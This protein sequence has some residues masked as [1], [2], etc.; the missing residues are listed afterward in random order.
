MSNATL[1]SA[2]NTKIL[3]MQSRL[4]QEEDYIRLIEM[5]TVD[6]QIDYLNTQTQYRDRLDGV[7]RV[8]EVELRMNELRYDELSKLQHYFSAGYRAF[9][10]A[11]MRRFEVEQIKIFLRG[12]QNDDPLDPLKLESILLHRTGED[13]PIFR[14]E[15][16]TSI[17]AYIENLRDT[18][19]FEVLSPYADDTGPGRL[20]YME[21]LLDK[22]YFKQLRIAA[23]GLQKKDREIVEQNLGIDID[24]KNIEFIYRGKR[25]YHLLPEEMINLAIDGGWRVKSD[26]IR[27]LAYAPL[28]EIRELILDSNYR[29]LFESEED[30]D[31][32]MFRSLRRYQYR[33]FEKHSHSMQKD[34]HLMLSYLHLTEYEIRDTIA[35]LEGR[36]YQMEKIEINDYLI[37]QVDSAK[38]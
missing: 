12:M 14:F 13:N 34:I 29:F 38:L 2:V 23:R 21:M 33:T 27:K 24:L 25:F 15:S 11:L 22:Y 5:P 18:P 37:A 3:S 9:F 10:L 1:F 30:V 16:R 32:E 7:R 19:Y 20:Y 28:E 17:P 26:F 36:R 4:L 8:D 31:L 6:A 35:I